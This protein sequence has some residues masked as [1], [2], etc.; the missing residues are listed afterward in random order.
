MATTCKMYIQLVKCTT[1]CKMYILITVCICLIC[2]SANKE[3]GKLFS[4]EKS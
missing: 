4:C 1:T 3:N 2:R